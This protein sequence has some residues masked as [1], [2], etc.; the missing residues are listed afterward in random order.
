MALRLALFSKSG[1]RAVCHD[2]PDHGLLTEALQREEARAIQCLSARTAAGIAAIGRN[3]GLQAE[4]IEELQCDC[5][6]LFIQKLR[7]GAYTYRG[8]DPASYVIETAKLRA[9]HYAR[10]ANRRRA[11]MLEADFD[12]ADPDRFD[13]SLENAGLLRTLLLLVEENCRA[14]I[15]LK[16][17]EGRSDK[18]VISLGITPYATE[19]S[20]KS[21]RA[22][23]MKKLAGAFAARRNKQI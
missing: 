12:P 19:K 3:R 6:V 9:R 22:K 4:D 10:Q 1:A 13:E 18:E 7:S 5:I 15:T 23:C 20:L 21:Q 8:H 16:Y 11:E 17:L 2:F 14:L